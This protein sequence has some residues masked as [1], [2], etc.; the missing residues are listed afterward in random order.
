MGTLYRAQILLESEQHETLKGIAE[1]DGR[2]LSQ[3]VREIVDLYLAE[4]ERDVQ[5]RQ[6]L[7][8]VRELARTRE[9]LRERHGMYR[10][11]PL[12]EVRAEREVD[13]ERVWRGEE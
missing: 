4:Q 9:Q 7:E 6:G 5:R 3:V 8:A 13:S 11:D 10:G 1:R 2:S 12:A